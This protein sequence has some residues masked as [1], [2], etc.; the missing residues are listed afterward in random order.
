MVD[1]VLAECEAV[2]QRLRTLPHGWWSTCCW[3]RC[4]SRSAATSR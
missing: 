1:E 2:Q 3:P 4:C